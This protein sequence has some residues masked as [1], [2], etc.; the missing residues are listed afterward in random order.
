MPHESSTARAFRFELIR[1]DGA[2]PRR[3]RLITPHGAV[4]T[5][6]FMPVGTAGAVKSVSPGE[7]AATGA[8]ILLGNTYHLGLRPGADVVASLGGLHKFMGWPGPIL[9]DSGGF[10]IFSLAALREVGES[11]VAFRSH[12]DGSAHVMTPE[13]AIEAQRMLGSDISMV[14]DECPP[15]SATRDQVAGAMRRTTAWSRRCREV[16][17]G[18]DGRALFGIV[19]GGVH[20][21]LRREH[22]QQVVEIG[23]DGYAVG[24]VSVGEAR[25]LIYDVGRWMG[26]ML[27]RAAPRYM[28]GLG[29][30]EDLIELVGS[31]FDMFDCVMPT[32]NARN[33]TLFTSRGLVHIRNEVHTRDAGP[34]DPDCDCMACSG[35]SRAYLRHLF[36]SRE[37]L[38]H[39]LNT[40]HNLA[41]YQRLM[42]GAREAIAAERFHAWRSDTLARMSEGAS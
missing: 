35:F 11:G 29:A 41:F 42:A 26:G 36:L 3:G 24:G 16:F 40:I 6:A 38:G 20:E 23:F 8:Q 12:L 1:A 32:R 14:L 10:Q 21:D 17:D 28:M 33:G 19:Q 34:L 18:S 13:S 27:P 5:P 15:A 2:G 9:T 4:E 22:A 37:I 7:V 30:P 31:G 39:R 25:D